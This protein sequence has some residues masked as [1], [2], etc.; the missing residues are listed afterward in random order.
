MFEICYTHY[1]SNGDA[2][3]FITTARV[4][5]KHAHN[6]CELCVSQ[7]DIVSVKLA[8]AKLTILTIP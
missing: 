2:K 8:S 3:L 6:Y 4:N 7:I 5:M 1:Y